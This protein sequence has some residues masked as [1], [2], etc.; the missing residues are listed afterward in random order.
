MPPLIVRA[1]G[2]DA[3]L[4]GQFLQVSPE[5]V[6]EVQIKRAIDG[7]GVIIHASNLSEA[8]QELSLSFPA[9]HLAGA[10][11]CSAI[12]EDGDALPIAGDTVTLALAARSVAFARVTFAS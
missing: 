8:A 3:S 11:G 6:A 10:W 5:G 7:R 1:A 12:E 4:N 9:V 2:A